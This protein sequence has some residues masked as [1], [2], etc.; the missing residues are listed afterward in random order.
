MG[1]GLRLVERHTVQ[2]HLQ[3]EFLPESAEEIGRL[4]AAESRP[5]TNLR[6]HSGSGTGT[7]K[8]IPRSR[9]A[10]FIDARRWKSARHCARGPQIE[11]PR[12]GRIEPQRLIDHLSRTVF[13]AQAPPRSCGIAPGVRIRRVQP[14]CCV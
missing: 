14:E 4:L 1:A 13:L 10:I 8:I 3:A 6:G 11:G 9:V 12:E 5:P 2:R 7:G